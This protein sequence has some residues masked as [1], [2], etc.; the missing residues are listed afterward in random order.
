M[1]N[2]SLNETLTETYEEFK[3]L[4]T[5]EVENNHEVDAIVNGF[6]DQIR[7]IAPKISPEFSQ[8][9]ANSLIN[10][11]K[12]GYSNGCGFGA[13]KMMEKIAIESGKKQ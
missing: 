9:L 11:Y 12:M 8:A 1:E 7:T 10:M 3:A 2:K 4:G 13:L 5:F 6:V